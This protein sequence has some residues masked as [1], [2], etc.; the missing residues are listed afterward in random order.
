MKF[1]NQNGEKGLGQGEMKKVK[2]LLKKSLRKFQRAVAKFSQSLDFFRLFRLGFLRNYPTFSV[3]TLKNPGD[4]QKK[5][6]KACFL[7]L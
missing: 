5:S 6:K 7:T 2:G 4:L 3:K 1:A